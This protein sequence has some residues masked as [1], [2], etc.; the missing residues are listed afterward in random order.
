MST[1]CDVVVVG[2]GVMGASTAW[3]LARRGV[4]VVLLERFAPGHDR[5]SSHG[6]TRIFRLAYDDVRYV[7]MAR[8][9]LPLWREL[10][11]DAGRVLLE[12]GGAIDH[13]PAA[14]VG[15]VADAL[16]AEGVA[17]RRLT[18]AEAAERWPGMRFDE[19]VLFHPQG[20]RCFAERTVTALC[21][22]A[23]AHGADVR[24]GM[25]R[26]EVELTSGGE[27]VVVRAH[28]AEWRPQTVVVT[29]GAW[30]GT[31]ARDLGV[32]LPPLKVTLEQVQ[33]FWPRDLGLATDPYPAWPPFIHHRPDRPFM[34]GVASPAEGVKIDEHHAGR[35][36]DP[37]HDPRQPDEGR[38]AEVVAYVTDW[39]PG[40][41]PA[42]VRPA[43]CLYT[44]TQDE[45]F[46]LERHGPVVIGS[47]CSGHGFKFAPWIGRELASL[48]HPESASP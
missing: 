46:V 23:A 28:R 37:D 26:A 42:P 13:G 15:A 19:A 21:D 2:A 27:G 34:Y 29:V 1:R 16:A 36:I 47:P 4:D 31:L 14:A 39:F 30:V 7:R 25:G 18:P 45:S 41:D 32:V 48:A 3:W 6:A 17:H 33:H 43:T 12:T 9:A 35:V 11:E 20:G 22:R 24:F 38:R 8:D 10:E 40:L 5:G 44:T